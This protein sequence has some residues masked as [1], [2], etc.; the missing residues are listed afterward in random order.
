MAAAAPPGGAGSGH[1]PW[2]L[3]LSWLR[4]PSTLPSAHWKGAGRDHP[5]VSPRASPDVSLPGSAK[6]GGLWL[7]LIPGILFPGKD[8]E[9]SLLT[10]AKAT[11]KALA[12]GRRLG[13]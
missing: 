6:A 2:F 3:P 8:Q 13:P 1:L 11:Q 5:I 10:K 12:L 4:E 9:G 7:A